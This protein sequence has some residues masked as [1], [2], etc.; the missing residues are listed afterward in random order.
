MCKEVLTADDFD[1]VVPDVELQVF[2]DVP[3]CDSDVAADV[4]VAFLLGF[5]VCRFLQP[6]RFFDWFFLSPF[7]VA[8]AEISRRD[9]HHGE[10]RSKLSW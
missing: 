5:R 6:R 7:I 3:E 8:L 2:R 1:S 9:L 10:G 4:L